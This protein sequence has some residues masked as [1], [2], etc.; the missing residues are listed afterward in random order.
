MTEP[1]NPLGSGGMSRA[2]ATTPIK[3]GRPEADPADKKV[4][5]SA[6]CFCKSTPGVGK[7]GRSLKQSCVSNR[8][9]ELDKILQHRSPFK[10]E[11]NYDMTKEPPA[12]IMDSGVDTKAH[13]WLPGFIKKWWDTPDADGNKRPP[14]K[15]G[16]GMVRRPDVVIVKDPSKP[17]T[18]DNIKQVVEIKF[19]PDAT[20]EAQEF[21][22][23]R[24]AGDDTKLVVM[25]PENCDCN[26]SEPEPSKVP[27]EELGVAGALAAIL[28]MLLTK[29]PPPVLSPA[30]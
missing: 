16:L 20:T 28:Y 18:Q 29:R 10:P 19:P 15:P 12:P 26:K 22:Y 24:I 23:K 3:I 8:L 2:G 27:V 11:V 4:L 25:G 13:D 9:G 1:S 17:P 5:C 14:F 7:D 6:I 30:L 21:D